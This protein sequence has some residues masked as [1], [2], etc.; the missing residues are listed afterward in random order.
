MLGHPAAFVTQVHDT[1][2]ISI[3]EL[4]NSMRGMKRDSSVCYLQWTGKDGE[5][6]RAASDNA[7][8]LKHSAEAKGREIR[9]SWSR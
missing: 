6:S 7:R 2:H 8:D 4:P 3:T 9:D 5:V 1:E